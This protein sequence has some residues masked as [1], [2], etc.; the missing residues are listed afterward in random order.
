MLKTIGIVVY[1]LLFVYLIA[2]FVVYLIKHINLFTF[3]TF[4]EYSQLVAYL[5]LLSARYVPYLY[6]SFKTFL[7]TH[8]L[9]SRGDMYPGND[10]S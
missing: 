6:D 5:P 8:C 9:F 1:I 3:W 2:H 7:M 10:Y 4:I